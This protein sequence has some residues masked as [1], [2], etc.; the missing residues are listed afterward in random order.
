MKLQ[1]KLA[2]FHSLSKTAIVILFILL[3][4]LLVSSVVSGY[5]N[6]LLEE[7]KQKVLR[8]ISRNGIDYYLAGDSSY[9]SYTMLKE[10]YISLEPSPP[11]LNL[12]N[13]FTSRRLIEGDTL[14]YRVLSYTFP[15]H[16][17]KYLLEI[18]KTLGSINQYTYPLQRVAL[19]VLISLVLITLLV[20]L[21]FTRILLRPL[22]RIIKTKILNRKFPFNEAP[23]PVNTSTTDF[24]FLDESLSGLETQVRS[25]FEKE[26]E[27]TSNAS[28]ELMTPISILQ[29][30]LENL[31]LEE[32]LNENIQEKINGMMAT[33][34]RLKKIVRILLMISRID[35]NQF[36]RSDEVAVQPML[37]EIGQELSDQ[38]EARNIHASVKP[39]PSISLHGVN[40]ELI[41]QCIFNLWHNAIRHN[42]EGGSIQISGRLLTD[43]AYVLSI[44]DT[45]AGIPASALPHIFDRFR[46]A[47]ENTGEGYGLGLSIVKSITDYHGIRIDVQSRPG[48]GSQF[49]LHF[50]PDFTS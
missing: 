35:N 3:L 23:I 21:I 16:G 37:H 38:M 29:N 9:G 45:G 42:R 43:G 46:K 15:D 18:G 24:R 4:P 10:E 2:L 31:M 6:H 26:R 7:Q 40:R 22:S 11:S 33:L 32:G 5:T 1:T 20:D 12:D 50:P 36:L 19:Y 8:N 14:T 44:E 41:F 48:R 17:R 34:D 49:S 13:I 39:E 30:K 28:H 25:A 47:G 27:F